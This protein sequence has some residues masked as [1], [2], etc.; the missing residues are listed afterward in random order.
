MQKYGYDVTVTSRGGHDGVDICCVVSSE[1][2]FEYLTSTQDWCSAFADKIDGRVVYTTHNLYDDVTKPEFRMAFGQVHCILPHIYC[3]PKG[4]V[5]RE[6]VVYIDDPIII[7]AARPAMPK[8]GELHLLVRGKENR[9]AYLGSANQSNL[10]GYGGTVSLKKEGSD[11]KIT[12]SVL[13]ERGALYGLAGQHIAEG[14]YELSYVSTDGKVQAT[15]P[16]HMKSGYAMPLLVTYNKKL[17]KIHLSE[18]TDGRRVAMENNFIGVRSQYNGV[19]TIKVVDE[20]GGKQEISAPYHTGYTVLPLPIKGDRK[21]T[22]TISQ[23]GTELVTA[24]YTPLC[25]ITD[26]STVKLAQ[27]GGMEVKLWNTQNPVDYLTL[28]MVRT[29]ADN[30]TILRLGLKQGVMVESDK[31]F[32][33]D[34]CVYTNELPVKV[35]FVV[36]GKVHVVN[37]ESD[38]AEATTKQEQ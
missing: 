35:S 22:V 26:V 38:S 4:E 27:L 20:F 24:E 36:D 18:T 34:N 33:A 1:E 7:E 28:D 6:Q 10:L 11:N 14:D 15:S 9:A 31:G 32:I 37:Y 5:L 8:A 3:R 17:P 13:E 2:P 30:E 25:M 12:L 21:S 19:I 23:Y 29:H 16:L